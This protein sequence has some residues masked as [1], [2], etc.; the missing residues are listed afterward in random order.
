[1]SWIILALFGAFWQASG[2]AIKKRALKTSGM[3]NVIGCM[4]FGFAGLIF[5]MS[6]V[7]EEQ[8]FW[9]GNLSLRFWEAMAWYAGLN[10]LAVWFKYKALSIAEFN[11]LMPFMTLTSLSL[12][13]PP[14]IF[15]G[16]FPSMQSFGG[17]AL[18]VFG[19][20]LMNYKSKNQKG[21]VHEKQ[22]EANRKGVW[23]FTVTALCYTFAPTAAKVAIQ[24]SSVLFTSFV[25]H[26]LIALGFFVI[27]LATREVNKLLYP[28]DEAPFLLAIL[29][30]G[31]VIVLENGS[32][33]AALSEASVAS[34]FALK[35]TM[36]F[37]AFVIGIVYFKERTELWKKFVATMFMVVGAV[38]VTLF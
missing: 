33:N 13:V 20:L 12:V 22:R 19:A 26:I 27:M 7:W 14:M 32:I 2:D 3:D 1:M 35:R 37:F 30:A 25:V 34:V 11:H 23:Y 17:I 5:W 18:V 31:V 21:E 29:A 36:P 6:F 38:L 28:F 15:L 16:E 10:V 8:S 24:E 4:S 9:I